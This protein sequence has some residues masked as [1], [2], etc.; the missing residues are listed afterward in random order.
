MS[1]QR[2]FD[3]PTRAIDLGQDGKILIR[4]DDKWKD[5]TYGYDVPEKVRRSEFDW[6]DDAESSDHFFKYHGTWHHLSQFERYSTG[7]LIKVSADGEQY[8]VATYRAVGA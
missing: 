6:L 8:K 5:F 4:T 3:N 2:V 7:I 1:W